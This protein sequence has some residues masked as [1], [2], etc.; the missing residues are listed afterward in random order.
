MC[1]ITGQMHQWTA[2]ITSHILRIQTVI[3]HIVYSILFKEKKTKKY[4][5]PKHTGNVYSMALS[6]KRSGWNLYKTV[7]HNANTMEKILPSCCAILLKTKTEA[8][9]VFLI[10]MISFVITIVIC[11]FTS[12]PYIEI[13]ISLLVHF[14]P[15]QKIQSYFKQ[16][17]LWKSL[18]CQTI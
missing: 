10:L 17:L 15:C 1:T 7:L 4:L 11:W 2:A 16:S 18:C 3:V 9:L 14:L 13:V 5:L 6:S 12:E 8:H